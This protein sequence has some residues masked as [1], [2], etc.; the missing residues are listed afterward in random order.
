MA[1]IV[2]EPRFAQ[3]AGMTPVARTTAGPPGRNDP[4]HCGSG[5]KYKHCCALKASA[6][7]SFQSQFAATQLKRG[8][9][10]EKNGRV[11]EA[12]LAYEL[13]AAESP[14]ARSRLARALE[15]LGRIDEAI[16]HFRAAAGDAPTDPKRCM[17]LAMALVLEERVAEAEAQLRAV[18]AADPTNG[19]A[20]ALLGR[21]LAESGRFD[22]AAACFDVSL[23]RQP[24]EAGVYYHLVRARRLTEADR[25]LLRR[26]LAAAPSVTRA[27]HKVKLHLAIAKAFDDLGDYGEAMRQIGKANALRKKL[28]AFDRASLAGYVDALIALFTPQFLARHARNGDPSRRPVLIVGM[29]RSGTTL[30]EQILSS[31][32]AVAGAGELR[33]WTGRETLFDGHDTDAWIDSRQAGAARDYLALLDGL[34]PEADRVIDKNPFNF[35]CLGLFHTAFPNGRIIH[36]R[37]HPIDTCLSVAS[38]HISAR[39]AFPADLEDLAYYYRQYQRLMRHWR[40]SLPSDT[41]VEVD[42]EAVIADPE[43]QSRALVAALGLEWEAACLRPQD[44]PRIVKTSSA[45]QVR[46]PIYSASLERWR[47]YAPWLGPLSALAAE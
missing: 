41:L 16:R 15:G 19:E 36:C 17:D 12:L 2:R 39:G 3:D 5:R 22:A 31:H 25:P 1:R 26:M 8:L 29:P 27:E 33:F 34:A 30:A 7:A 40:A 38:T 4:C 10:L 43:R 46:Q 47:R 32:S 18:T 37:R 23:A 45:W 11:E 28:S 14:E 24:A 21:I 35:F 42:Y 20:H 13:A 44:N 9:A 6:A